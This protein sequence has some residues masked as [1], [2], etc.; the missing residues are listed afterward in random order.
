MDKTFSLLW[1]VNSNRSTFS[2][3]RTVIEGLNLDKNFNKALFLQLAHIPLDTEVIKFR[4]EVF[5]DLKRNPVILEA[6]CNFTL[7]FD[8]V[9][10]LHEMLNNSDIK[11]QGLLDFNNILSDVVN[12]DVHLQFLKDN[13]S[14]Q[15]NEIKNVTIDFNIGEEL[16]PVSAKLIS[17]NKEEIKFDI[18]NSDIQTSHDLKHYINGVCTKINSSNYHIKGNYETQLKEMLPENIIDELCFYAYSG[19]LEPLGNIA[20]REKC[21]NLVYSSEPLRNY[22][23]IKEEVINQLLYQLGVIQTEMLTPV[24]CIYMYLG[25]E[26]LSE[27]QFS[28]DY[29]KINQLIKNASESSLILINNSF[30]ESISTV[31]MLLAKGLVKNIYKMN[32][33]ALV[34]TPF[35][36]LAEFAKDCNIRTGELI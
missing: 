16:K 15:Q 14:I 17:I 29:F 9:S 19:K 6:I 18:E 7:N 10:D 8:K 32:C 3:N 2:L 34:I 26:K 23:Y 4:Q 25:P 13:R 27:N 30:R 21:L 1:P 33:R 20:K 11:S 31:S 12:S 28:Q 5:K 22:E 24:D 35:A 36:E